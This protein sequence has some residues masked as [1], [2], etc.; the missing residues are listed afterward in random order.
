M[1]TRPRSGFS[2]FTLTALV[3]L[4]GLVAA[5]AQT[6]SFQKSEAPKVQRGAKILLMT[7]DIELYEISAGG[8]PVPKA[9]WT[10]EA[11]RHVA[12]ALRQEFSDAGIGLVAYG[13]R[14]SEGADEERHQQ[15]VKLHRA[16]GQ[17]ILVH[18]YS[19]KMS[20]PT[21]QDK[22]DWTLGAGAAVL[23]RAYGA[24]YG[25]FVYLRDSYA[26]AGRTALIIAA[27]ILFG[28]SVEGGT[29]LGFAS[30]V[31]LRTGDIVWFNRLVSKY[32]D[33]R[34][35]E[36]ARAAVQNLLADMPK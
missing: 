9:D 10:A 30:L 33:L 18:K 29:Q 13:S 22:F 25:L 12:S 4:V 3:V 31:D 1:P 23:R 34:S 36:R 11:Q 17:A 19:Q 27:A 20:L 2:N 5:C 32:G 8:M 7:P 24:D 35:P 6:S 26:T 21:K 15:I 14:A 28:V 16:V